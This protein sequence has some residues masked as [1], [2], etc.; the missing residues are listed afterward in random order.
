MNEQHA[1]LNWI[2]TAIGNNELECTGAVLTRIGELESVLNPANS[3]LS[4]D[5]WCDLSNVESHYESF[6]NKYGDLACFLSDYKQ[7]HYELYCERFKIYGKH[8]TFWN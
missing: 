4:F 8:T 7:Y 5:E 2:Y 1:Q 3:P 6:H